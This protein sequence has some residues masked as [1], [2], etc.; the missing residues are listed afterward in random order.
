M[1]GGEKMATSIYDTWLTPWGTGVSMAPADPWKAFEEGYTPTRTVVKDGEITGTLGR[2]LWQRTPTGQVLGASTSGG[3]DK[4]GGGGQPQPERKSELPG[5]G[6]G[7]FE[8]QEV[9]LEGWIWRW[10]GPYW[11]KIR[12]GGESAAAAQEEAE[13][14]AAEAEWRRV[15]EELK[16]RKGEVGKEKERG[17]KEIETEVERGT[18][19][20]GRRKEKQVKEYGK[21]LEETKTTIKDEEA[22]LARNFRD[23]SLKVAMAMRASGVQLSSYSQ[24]RQAELEDI[25]M[26]GTKELAKEGTKAV[27]LVNEAIQETNDYYDRKTDELLE[28][29]RTAKDKIIDWYNNQ[30]GAINRELSYNDFTRAA[31]IRAAKARAAQSLANVNAQIAQQQAQLGMWLA[32]Q[33]Y[34]IDNAMAVAAAGKS[35]TAVDIIERMTKNVNLVNKIGQAA[36]QG[37]I[38]GIDENTR[39][40]LAR[41]GIWLPETQQL[42]NLYQTE[43][44]EDALKRALMAGQA[45]QYKYLSDQQTSQTPWWQFWK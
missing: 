27:S 4:S 28:W 39:K 6:K 21:Q 23:M 16:A 29:G 41:Q 34:A 14:A 8:G 12:K 42:I 20:L 9:G 33:K 37:L 18:G 2:A 15:A 45:E 10:M 7:Q 11:E 1:K 5:W 31:E 30:I 26:R 36:T 43:A 24:Q 22:K 13:R 35:E 19:E 38:M 17:L 32:Q 40:E 25:Y 3:G 44:E